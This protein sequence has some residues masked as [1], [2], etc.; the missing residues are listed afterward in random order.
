VLKRNQKN[1]RASTSVKT[2]DY[3]VQSVPISELHINPNNVRTHP[4][5]QVRQIAN[6][7]AAFGCL[8]PALI[9]ENNMILAG[10]GRIEA[11]KY[12]GVTTF[13]VLRVQHLSEAQKRA[14]MIAD[15]KLAQNAGWD[16]ERLYS[17][18]KDLSLI[19][20]EEDLDLELTGFETAELDALSLDFQE[21]PGGSAETLPPPP[22]NPVCCLGDLW[23]L[24]G[25]RIACGD[26]RSEA[27][28]D[29]LMDGTKAF[30]VIADAPYNVRIG[31]HVGG[32]GRIKHREFVAA[33]GELSS[34]QFEAFLKQTLGLCKQYSIDGSIHY[35]CMDWRHLGELLAAGN[36]IYDELK[37]ICVWVKTNAGQGSFY[38]S[39]HELVLVFKHGDAEHLNT[40]ELG[41]H[42]RTR[43]NVWNY[44]GANT[45]SATRMNDLKMHP[46]VKPTALV[47]DAMKDCSK[48]GSIVL[49]P[50]LGSGTT[51][52]GAEQVGRRAYGIELDPAYVDVA[53]ERWQRLTKRDAVL[54]G[55]PFTF[56]E[57]RSDPGLRTKTSTTAPRVKR[58][59][60]R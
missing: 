13:P 42:G 20:V 10:H 52:I 35:V 36:A 51:V 46:T 24:G 48:R 29:R 60:A 17:E 28:Y 53:I 50:F 40:F 43:T 2:M 32:R 18:L 5:R 21:I 16:R 55:T 33:S 8:V 47:V 37:N 22:I 38:R 58:R 25:H 4:K 19:L 44:A 14:Y 57:L 41:Q 59:R 26:A 12:L 30:M 45:F 1:T 3:K 11:A 6:S 15:N 39:Q 54:D 23:K 49:D 34:S 9:D 27:V 56:D 31:G 7:I